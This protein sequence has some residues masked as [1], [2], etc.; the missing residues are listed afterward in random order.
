ML[1]RGVMET[2]PFVVRF[3]GGDRCCDRTRG[4]GGYRAFPI[5]PREVQHGNFARLYRLGR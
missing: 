5:S 2:D 3:L 1:A 4:K